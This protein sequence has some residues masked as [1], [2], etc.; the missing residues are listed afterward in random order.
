MVFMLAGNCRIVGILGFCLPLLQTRGRELQ[1]KSRTSPTVGRLS[2][3]AQSCRASRGNINGDNYFGLSSQQLTH[4]SA[5]PY[6]IFF[7][8]AGMSIRHG[9]WVFGVPRY[10]KIE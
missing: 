7:M 10:L 4:L 8:G 6:A 9:A 1:R 3:P 5:Q 2:V